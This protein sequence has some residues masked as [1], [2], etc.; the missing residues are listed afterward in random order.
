ME[1]K[2]EY[3]ADAMRERWWVSFAHDDRIYA[4]RIV[5]EGGKLRIG[6]AVGALESA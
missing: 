3:L 4:A 1:R 6:D 5:L 2:A